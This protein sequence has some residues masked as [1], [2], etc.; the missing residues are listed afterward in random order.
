LQV[1]A[2]PG[3]KLFMSIHPT[4]SGRGVDAFVEQAV[5]AG[6]PLGVKALK[7]TR[8]AFGKL[9][10]IIDEFE[11]VEFEFVELE[12]VKLE[13]VELEFVE[14]EFVELEL[15]ELEFVELVPFEVQFVIEVKFQ[16]VTFNIVELALGVPI[17][18]KLA[19]HD[20]FVVVELLIGLGA[21]GPRIGLRRELAPPTAVPVE[22]VDVVLLAP[23]E[24]LPI[25]LLPP[26]VVVLPIELELPPMELVLAPLAVLEAGIVAAPMLGWVMAIG[27][28][29]RSLLPED[30]G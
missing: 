19:A 2:L 27:C 13:L 25:V 18:V 7:H 12:F 30:P 10:T 3:F 29:C 5:A 23:V 16:L 11:F 1:S 26:I 6:G 24:L 9:K 14:L 21:G 20:E 4:G 28:C 22:T 8:V 15:V 17:T